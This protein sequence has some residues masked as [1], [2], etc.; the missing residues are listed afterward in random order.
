M[1]AEEALKYGIV[2]NVI[3]DK[4]AFKKATGTDGRE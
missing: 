1:G 4:N 2:D 3:Y